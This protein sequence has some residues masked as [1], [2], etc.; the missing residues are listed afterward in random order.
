MGQQA[1]PLPV[2]RDVAVVTRSFAT[3]N[4]TPFG[5]PASPVSLDPQANAAEA[6]FVKSATRYLA[7]RYPSPASAK[8]AGYVRYT[9]EDQ[10]GII[11]YTNLKWFADDP[12]NPTQLWYDA[13]GR[14]L[15]ADYTMRVTDRSRRPEVWGLQPGRWSHFI[16]HIH[17]VVREDGKTDYRSMLNDVYKAN[18]GDPA[19]PRG[20]PIVR[21][22]FA[23]R[24]SDVTLIFELP[25]IWIASV[26]LV[27]NPKGAFAD[28]DPLVKPTAGA[29]QDVHPRPVSR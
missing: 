3:P 9:A 7:A 2:F 5:A 16:A 8:A 14:F 11:T 20:E 21:A 12:Q 27:P 6:K 29:R 1:S 19:H 17:Y 26:W 13:H 24:P 18:G 28:S 15:G 25:E 22:G 10:D 23:K 4:Q